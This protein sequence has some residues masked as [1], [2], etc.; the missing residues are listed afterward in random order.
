MHPHPS[1]PKPLTEGR[2]HFQNVT[3]PDPNNGTCSS[4]A[5]GRVRGLAAWRRNVD[6]ERSGAVGAPSSSSAT[7]RSVRGHVSSPPSTLHPPPTSRPYRYTTHK[8]AGCM[9]AREFLTVREAERSRSGGAEREIGKTIKKKKREREGKVWLRSTFE[10]KALLKLGSPTC[11]SLRSRRGGRGKGGGGRGDA[12]IF[13]R[14]RL[15]SEGGRVTKEED[16]NECLP[17]LKRQTL[18]FCLLHSP[19]VRRNKG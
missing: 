8:R 3:R 2:A 9:A 13:R 16:A 12:A 14:C 6:P 5:G 15:G 1:T 17:S 11:L 18:V 10:I 19:E 7:D 4:G